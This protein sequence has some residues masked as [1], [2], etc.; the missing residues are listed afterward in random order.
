MPVYDL[1][2]TVWLVLYD[3]P[4]LRV[5]AQTFQPDFLLTGGPLSVFQGLLPSIWA[6]AVVE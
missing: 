3:E 2:L 1:Q 6:E 4:V 5:Q